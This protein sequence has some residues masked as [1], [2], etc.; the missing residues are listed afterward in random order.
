MIEC[1]LIRFAS[2]VSTNHNQLTLQIDK[3][4][5]MPKSL[6]DLFLLSLYVLY[7]IECQ[8]IYLP[9]DKSF[10]EAKKV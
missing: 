8:W 2:L 6:L 10:T 4:K 5:K 1:Q 3:H 7:L 9:I